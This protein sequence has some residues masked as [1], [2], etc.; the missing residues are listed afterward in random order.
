MVNLLIVDDDLNFCKNITN[1]LTKNKNVRICKICTNGLE[2]LNVL[3][4]EDIDIIILD[5]IMPTCNGIDVLNALS[6]QK[7][8]KYNNSIIVISGEF[9]FFQ[10]LVNN[11]FVYDYIL[12]GSSNDKVLK[13]VNKLIENKDISLQR[14]KIANELKKIGYDINYKGTIYLIDAIFQMYLYKENFIDNLQKDIYPIISKMYNKSVHN[15]K[16]NITNATELMYYKCDINTLKEYFN[17]YDDTKPTVKTV[18]YTVLNK[19]I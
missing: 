11:P 3:N 13:Q 17:F 7:N 14:A 8:S 4:K 10:Q 16:C 5:I 18:I 9:S 12:K 2:A 19:I 15:I 1:V 6:S